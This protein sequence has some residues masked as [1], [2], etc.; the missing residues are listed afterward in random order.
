[1]FKIVDCQ[2]IEVP[3]NASITPEM[4]DLREMMNDFLQRISAD[5][6]QNRE[7]HRQYLEG[8]LSGANGMEW[9]M[10]HS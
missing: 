6:P 4:K 8:R 7:L 2:P 5:T 9:F 3:D 1:M 10:D